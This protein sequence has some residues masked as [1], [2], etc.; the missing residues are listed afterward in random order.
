MTDSD[1]DQS[2][3]FYGLDSATPFHHPRDSCLADVRKFWQWTIRTT[4][5]NIMDRR[6]KMNRFDAM[7]VQMNL[8]ASD[9]WK[10]GIFF[11]T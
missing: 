2:G 3:F 1:P 9:N 7:C 4:R 5:F 11:E 6:D 10:E 8:N